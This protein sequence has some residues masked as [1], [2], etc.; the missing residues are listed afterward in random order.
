MPLLLTFQEVMPISKT[1]NQLYSMAEPHTDT[2]G[3][4]QHQSRK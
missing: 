1:C 3:T 4:S 2:L